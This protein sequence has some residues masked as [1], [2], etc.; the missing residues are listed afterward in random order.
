[1]SQNTCRKTTMIRP[2]EGW[3]SSG[4]KD[5]GASVQKGN[6]QSKTVIR[7]A[8]YD[9]MSASDKRAIRRGTGF[10]PVPDEERAR[11][12]IDAYSYLIR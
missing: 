3:R 5:P 12:R 2:E 7:L 11:Q 4:R 10:V 1:M 8:G 9:K 6:K